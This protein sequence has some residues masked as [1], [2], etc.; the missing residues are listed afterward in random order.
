M[1]ALTKEHELLQGLVGEW[2]GTAKTWLDPGKDPDVSPARARMRS[3]L[4]GL[5][6]VQEHEGSLQGKPFTG[7]VVYGFDG[8]TRKF[9]SF[10]IDDFH[11]GNAAMLSEGTADAGGVIRLFGHYSVPGGG[12]AW[13]WRSVIRP[14]KDGLVLEAWNVSPEGKEERAIETVYTRLG[15]AGS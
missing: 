10:W 8:S 1:D 15:K 9:T 2:E 3:V 5:F 14:E 4:G 13:G 7:M 6:L 12:Q 11:M